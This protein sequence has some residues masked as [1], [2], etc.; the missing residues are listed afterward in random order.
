VLITGSS[1]Q[2]GTN[3]ALT[4]RRSGR[5]VLGLDRRPNPWT[6]DF[7]TQVV[8]LVEV[9]RGKAACQLP[10]RPDVVVHLAAYAKVHDLVLNPAKG[11]ENREMSAAVFELGRLANSPVIFGSS[12]EVY[13][14]IEQHVTDES[15]AD[16]VVAKSPYSASKIAGEALLYSYARCYG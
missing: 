13:G 2:I 7:E 11:L 12:R 6:S 4:L 9:A 10:F 5:E 3:L 8:D 14:D 15:M 1:G 16:F